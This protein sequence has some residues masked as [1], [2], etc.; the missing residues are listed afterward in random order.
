MDS[1]FDVGGGCTHGCDPFL[2]GFGDEL[3][4]IVGADVPGNTA[5]D[6]QVGQRVDDVDGLEPSGYADG[7]TLAGE[8]ID[9]VEHAD[10]APIMGAV[11]N[12]VVGP[13]VI[14]VLG[15]QPDTGAVVQPEPTALRLRPGTF[16]PSRRQIRSTR[17][18]LTSQPARRS[19]SATLR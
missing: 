14:A 17:L 2:H 7:Q 5:K 12:K 18:S 13:D 6:E 15:P 3:R 10:P 4:S 9:D 19:S 1:S 16:S 11:L 8:L